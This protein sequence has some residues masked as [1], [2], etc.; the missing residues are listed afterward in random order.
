MEYVKF[1]N[2]GIQV[3]RLCLGVMDF[4]GRIEKKE[5]IRLILKALDQGINFID[6]AD[7]YGKGLS[8]EI[9][10]EALS[11]E[12]RNKVILATKFWEKMEDNPNSGGCSRYHIM[13][14]VEASLKRL[15]TD[16][17]DLYLLHHP[18]PKTPVEET[19]STLDTLINQG[20]V[21]YIG[22]CNHYAWQ[23][24]HMLGL[25]TLHNW[26]PIVCIQDRYSMIHRVL[27]NETIPFCK[28]F[29]IATMTYGP[30]A[31]GILAGRYKRGKPLPKSSRAD[32]M[33]FIRD[34]LTD[35][36]FDLLDALE[37][38]ASKY[39]IGLNRLSIAWLL[40]KPY[41]TS[42]ILGGS[43]PEHY[44]TVYPVSEDHIEK[45]DLQKIDEL[46]ERFR[47]KAYAHFY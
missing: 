40:S 26:E 24:T 25:S 10:G 45:E 47:D 17:I 27:E 9:L 46:S 12:K 43:R 23:M 5:S 44:E 7:A 36:T 31:G 13:K 16:Y 37:K 28:R 20:K 35:E 34:D 42:V 8:E 15:K 21:R 38:I 14:A 6:T 41:V 3:S 11:P 30:L 39:N 1:G 29:N 22:V 18:D 4:P 2:A 33:K 19:L 32:R